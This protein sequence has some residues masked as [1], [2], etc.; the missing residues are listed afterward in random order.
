MLARNCSE[1]V[2]NMKAQSDPEPPLVMK[3]HWALDIRVEQL[4]LVIKVVCREHLLSAVKR[5]SARP[6]QLR[7]HNCIFYLWVVHMSHCFARVFYSTS[8]TLRQALPYLT[9]E[10]N[11]ADWS[12]CLSNIWLSLLVTSFLS[13]LPFLVVFFVVVMFLFC[14]YHNCSI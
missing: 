4:M 1:L 5:W 14:L 2:F 3:N 9:C 6:V 11:W 13:S 7:L 8:V 10:Y 12:P